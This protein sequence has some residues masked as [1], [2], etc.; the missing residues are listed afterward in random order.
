VKS[1]NYL[2]VL[3]KKTIDKVTANNIKEDWVEEREE[4]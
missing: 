2:N 1:T 3:Q 4:K